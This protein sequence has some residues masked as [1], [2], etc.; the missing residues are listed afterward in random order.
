MNKKERYGEIKTPTSCINMMLDMLPKEVFLGNTKWLDPCAGDGRF[1]EQ[2]KLRLNPIYHTLTQIEINLEYDTILKSK[3]DNVFITD[4]LQYETSCTYD[5]IIGNPPYNINGMKKTPTNTKYSKQNDGITIWPLFIRKCIEMLH[6]NGYLCMIVPS[7]WLKPDKAK[8][9][10]LLLSYTIINIRS[11]T[12]TETKKIFNGNAQTPTTI[13]VLQKKKQINH[14]FILPIYDNHM[15]RFV[16]Y[17]FKY[18]YPIPT[19]YPSIIN[20]IM[21]YVY[22]YGSIDIIKTNMPNQKVNIGKQNVYQGI[23]T[24]TLSDGFVITESTSPYP[25]QNIPKIIMAH[26]MYGI[27]YYDKKGQYGISNRDN[28]VFLQDDKSELEMNKY[29]S[30]LSS[31]IALFVFDV[32]R[33]RMKYLEKYAFELI[34]DI[35]HI[36]PNVNFANDYEICNC[37][38]LSKRETDFIIQTYSRHC[39]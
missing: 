28:Y 4:F 24:Y 30:Y 25:Y 8:I 16:D 33:Y 9:Y 11:F 1:I 14:S 36:F 21:K 22:E 12:N 2:V 31:S 18:G 27:P 38:E 3:C 37:F 23:K 15:E 34:P 32:T 26:K 6:D 5:I 7:I 10:D 13:F 17:D 29:V 35:I 19:N 20:K 39:N